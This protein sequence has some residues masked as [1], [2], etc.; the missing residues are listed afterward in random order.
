MNQLKSYE[1]FKID[2]LVPNKRD[3]NNPFMSAAI[4]LNEFEVLK[5]KG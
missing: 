1:N 2:S 3:E 5:S 4:T